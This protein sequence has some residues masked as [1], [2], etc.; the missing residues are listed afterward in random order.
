[1]ILCILFIVK[2]K[3]KK[4]NK[5][6]EV[7]KKMICVGVL[8][9]SFMLLMPLAALPKN[10]DFTATAIE[11][12]APVVAENNKTVVFR[13]LNKESGEISE[14]TAAEYI[15]GVVAAEMPALYESE[16]LKAQAVASYTYAYCKRLQNTKKDYDISTDFATDPSFKT[17]EQAIKDWGEKGEEYADKIQSAVESVI[18]EIIIYEDKPILSVYHAVSSGQ[19]YSA[20]DVWGQDYGYLK[21][22]SSAWDK[23]ADN[24]TAVCEFTEEELKEKLK[25]IVDKESDK[26]PIIGEIKCKSSGIVES[27]KVCGQKL[28]GSEV[29]TALGLSSSNFSFEKKSGKYVFTSTGYGHGVGMSQYG[30][31]CMAKQGYSYDQIIMHYYSNVKIKK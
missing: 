25:S 19:T 29:R 8:I 9:F 16:A 31:N 5:K 1:M 13:V 30:A 26:S 10:G 28:S 7:M 27:V 12:S 24:Y 21:G 18:G 11:V 20:K 2:L 3:V 6:G 4:V 22:V 23:L 14:M 17:R 15:F